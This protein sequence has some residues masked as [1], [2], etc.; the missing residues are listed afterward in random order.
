[1]YSSQRSAQGKS[2]LNVEPIQV[3]LGQQFPH[4]ANTHDSEH[5]AC[6]RNEFREEHE[7]RPIAG[8]ELDQSVRKFH[9][10]LTGTNGTK[11]TF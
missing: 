7:N 1:V 2:K 4:K 5:A 10:H 3:E 6:K 9:T 11:G 8:V